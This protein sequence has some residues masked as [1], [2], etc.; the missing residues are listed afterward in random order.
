M[1]VSRLSI[2]PLTILGVTGP[3]TV[4]AENIYTL[5]IGS[6]AVRQRFIQSISVNIHIDFIDTIPP[7]YGLVLN[8]RRLD[9]LSACHIQRS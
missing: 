4:L 9:A 6:F 3:F 8:S 1:G 2:Q 5:C 7:L